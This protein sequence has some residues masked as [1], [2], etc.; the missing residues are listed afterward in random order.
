MSDDRVS[1]SMRFRTSA[2]NRNQFRSLAMAQDLQVQDFLETMALAWINTEEIT[3]EAL[4]RE[5]HYN[6]VDDAGRMV[7]GVLDR[8][9]RQGSYDVGGAGEVQQ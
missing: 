5:I 1:M 3:R 2:D 8:Y 7:A 6:G 9:Y 4:A